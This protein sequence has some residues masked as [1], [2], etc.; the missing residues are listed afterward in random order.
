MCS[1]CM[2]GQKRK[3]NRG[4]LLHVCNNS[5]E[6]NGCTRH[7]YVIFTLCPRSIYGNPR[8]LLKK[9]KPHSKA[10]RGE[11]L[12]RLLDVAETPLLFPSP[13]IL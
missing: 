1:P 4:R 5:C 6:C 13:N 7:E 2:I 9:A 3:K 11:R 10:L 12:D 8:S